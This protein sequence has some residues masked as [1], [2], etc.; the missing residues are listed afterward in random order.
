[1]TAI[2]YRDGVMAADTLVVSEFLR[3]PNNP[4]QPKAFSLALRDWSTA[5]VGV[6]GEECPSNEY[7]VRW[8]HDNPLHDLPV[9]TG[10]FELLLATDRGKILLVDQDGDV[11]EI[12]NPFWA[13]GSGAEI[14]MGFMA[15][16]GSAAEAVAAAIKWSPKC[17][18]DV[19]QVRL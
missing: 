6:A 3:M 14:C 12:R 17:G 11:S 1:M 15:A 18:G 10:K 2:A 19:D 8:L 5:L 16:G 7:I 9:M 13:I 4:E